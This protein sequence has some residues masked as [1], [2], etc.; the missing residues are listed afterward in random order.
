[1]FDPVPLSV[2]GDLLWIGFDNDDDDDVVVADGGVAAM[3]RG[4]D[5]DVLR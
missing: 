5:V 2:E 1:M 3:N 4:D